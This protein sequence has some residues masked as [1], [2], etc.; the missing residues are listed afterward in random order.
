M[1]VCQYLCLKSAEA[2][3]GETL[4]TDPSSKYPPEVT[5]YNKGA[6]MSVH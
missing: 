4:P 2:T 5:L 1:H 6:L 3:A